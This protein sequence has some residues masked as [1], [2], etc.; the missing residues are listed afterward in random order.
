MNRSYSVIDKAELI[1][2]PDCKKFRLLLTLG[3]QYAVR[4]R[5]GNGVVIATDDGQRIIILKSR[6]A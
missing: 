3:K 2:F 4:G 5:I 1:S 6:L